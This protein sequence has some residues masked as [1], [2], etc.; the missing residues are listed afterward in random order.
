VPPPE[1][2][3]LASF[4]E[5]TDLAADPARRRWTIYNALTMTLGTDWDEQS[6]PYSDPTN[7]EIAMDMAPDRYRFVLGGPVV[8]EP[9]TR[10]IYNGGATALLAR[11]IERGAGRPLHDF[12]RASLFDPLGIGPT[13]WLTDRDGEAIAASGLRMTLR[14]LARIG[15]MMLKGGMWGDRHVVPAEWIERSTSPMVD[16]DEIRQ[17][18]Y[19][20][21][22]GKFAFTV[23]TGPG[24]NRSRL[25]RFWSAMGNGGQRLF[26]FPGLD[27]VVAITAGNYDAPDQWVPPTRVIRE[28]VLPSIL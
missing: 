22:L 12:A 8:M 28:V 23:S 7:S 6:V 10:W 13:E 17:Y 27:L 1:A 5:Y 24:W 2:P 20:W 11:I 18:G 19:H 9:G 16:V 25:E 4:P 21:Y 14:G 15:S 3:L 26:V